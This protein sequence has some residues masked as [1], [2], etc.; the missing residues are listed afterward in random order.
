MK[1]NPAVDDYIAKAPDF[2]K[3]ILTHIRD[4]V[5]KAVPEVEEEMKWST[6]NFMHKGMLCGMAT[7]K[8]H[9]GLGFWKGSASRAAVEWIA[10]GKPR[11][12]KY[13]K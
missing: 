7:F 5:H 9:C 3:P 10:E 4:V 8:Q 11:H 1:R 13:Q 12:W 2:A 6:P